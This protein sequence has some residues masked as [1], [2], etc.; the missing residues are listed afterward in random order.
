MRGLALEER[1]GK[2]GAMKRPGG[3]EKDA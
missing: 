2:D 1:E 3:N